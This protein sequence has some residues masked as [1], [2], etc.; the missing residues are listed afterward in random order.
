MSKIAKQVRA[1]EGSSV[2][3]KAARPQDG[4]ILIVENLKKRP[5]LRGAA[6]MKADYKAR[7]AA[8]GASKKKRTK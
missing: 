4:D 1:M 3:F 5:K 6:K 2:V 7:M 8:K